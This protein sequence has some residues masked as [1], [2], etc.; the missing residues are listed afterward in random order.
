MPRITREQFN[1]WNAK[2]QGGFK[3]DLRHYVTWGEKT[4]VKTI[5]RDGGDVLEIRLAYEDEYE[6]R[7]S[8]AGCRYRVETGRHIPVMHMQYWTP[9]STPGVYTSRDLGQTQQ[10]GDPQ[11]TKSYDVL[12]KKSA[13]Y[14][15]DLSACTLDRLA[16]WLSQN[17]Q[18]VI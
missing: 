9:S 18:E 17:E 1:R 10:I 13:V 5:E 4:L 15:A 7:H 3:F 8:A 2:A 11:K 6:T 16:D 14:G 12:C